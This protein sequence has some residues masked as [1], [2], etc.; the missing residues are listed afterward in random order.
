[1]VQ[2]NLQGLMQGKDGFDYLAA[3]GRQQLP[4]LAL[5]GGR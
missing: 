2:W 3:L 5:A 1:M 4:V